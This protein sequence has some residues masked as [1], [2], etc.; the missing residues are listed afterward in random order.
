M[1]QPCGERSFPAGLPPIPL[2]VA[3]IPAF[4]LLMPGFLGMM[5]DRTGFEIL[6]GQGELRAQEPPPLRPPDSVWAVAA[7]YCSA[8]AL[9]SAIAGGGYREL[10]TTPIRVPVARLDVLAEG[11]LSPV[12]LG[13]GMTTQTLHLE[14]PDG[15]RY[16]FR[17]V[18][19]VTRQALAEE[20]WGTP[21]EAVMRDQLCSFHPSGAMIVDRLLD[22]V[23]VLHPSPRLLVVPDD[24]GLGEFRQ[25]FAGMLV[26]FEERPDDL[27]DGEAG[28]A[29]S[30]R[31]S[32]TEDL[33]DELEDHP[34]DRVVSS[35]LLKS[36]LVDLLVGDRDRSINNYL[37]AR[38]D[39]GEE[40]HVWRPV[41]RD[42]DQAFV[43]FDG[44]AKGIG[45]GYEPRLVSFGPRFSSVRGLTRNA[46]D[47]DRNLLVRLS[48]EEWDA[49]VAEVAASIS[50]QVI[51]EAVGTLPKAHYELVGPELADALKRRRDRLGTAAEDLYRIVFH[52]ADIHATDE[53]ELAILSQGRDGGILLTILP[54][55]AEEGTSSPYFRRVFSPLETREIRIYLHGGDDR[56]RLE[57][58]LESSMVVRIIGGGGEDEVMG[59]AGSVRLIFYDEDADTRVAARGVRWDRSDAGRPLSWWVDG[60]GQLDFGHRTWP[61]LSAGYDPDRG[62]VAT[63]GFIRERFGFLKEPFHSRTQMSLGWAFGRSEPMVDLEYHRR[64]VPG[65]A[66]LQLRGRFSGFEVIRFYGFGNDTEEAEPP[67][68]YEVHQRQLALGASLSFG[69]GRGRK[70]TVGP[71]FRRTQSDTTNPVNLVTLEQAYGTGTFLQAGI[72]A[73][74]EL[75]QRD[76]GTA[77]AQGYRLSGGGSFYPAV[78]DVEGPFGEVHGEA[79]V[80]LSPASRNPTLA[81]RAGGKH[82]WGRFP[83]SDAAFLGGSETVRGLREERFAGR[84]SLYGSAEIRVFLTRFLLVFPTDLGVFGLSDLG[85]VFA[86]GQPSGGWHTAFGGGVWL[87]PVNR[88]ATVKASIA[89]SE[90]GTAFYVGTGFAF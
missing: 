55:G 43:R 14:S 1:R 87:A 19:K 53:D 35:E 75:D 51:E 22:E 10:W 65:G 20:F 13:G 32:Q 49:G 69:D 68:F 36:R 45:R 82:L 17:S 37:W 11:G 12:R 56:V 60:E 64:R 47:I 67:S 33:F 30:R 41:P 89:Q 81:L 39:R 88:S 40:E 57:E 44:L 71:V 84:A 63:A 7:P 18:R 78:L 58:E 5:E 28:F 3:L 16:V 83:Y 61:L 86:E 23:G 74:V 48:R 52:E 62:V 80:Y 46:W 42:R 8:G 85:R 59:S 26:L 54:A 24:P 76:L 21:V 73:S 9:T 90:G 31:I 79:A 29:G 2:T 70:L 27:P 72:Q 50:D 34:G 6:Q 4:L 66:D 15:R 38:F 25:Q 77:P